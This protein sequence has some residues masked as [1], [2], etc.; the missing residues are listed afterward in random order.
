MSH[1][2]LYRW[3]LK[4]DREN[5]FVAAWARLTDVLREQCGAYGSRLHRCTDG[6]YLAYS[7]WPSRQAWELAQIHAPKSA[8]RALMA[9]AIEE[10]FPDSHMDVVDDRIDAPPFVPGGGIDAEADSASG[11]EDDS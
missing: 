5:D 6:T 8:A 7:Y 11:A 1:V 3:K 4:T 2:V 10:R 9:A